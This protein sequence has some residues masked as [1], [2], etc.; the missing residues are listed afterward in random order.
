MNPIYLFL[1]PFITLIVKN[2]DSYAQ[3][4]IIYDRIDIFIYDENNIERQQKTYDNTGIFTIS[5]GFQTIK[6]Y[7]SDTNEL[8]TF[9]LDHTKNKV[10]LPDNDEFYFYKIDNK[11][12]MNVGFMFDFKN[13]LLIETIKYSNNYTYVFYHSIKEIKKE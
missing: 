8:L 7:N 9:T 1:I 5:K 12:S 10:V 6:S 11:N 13:N 4:K 3:L 2:N